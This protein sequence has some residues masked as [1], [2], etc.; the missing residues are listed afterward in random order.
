MSVENK[1]FFEIFKIHQSDE[2][3]AKQWINQRKRAWKKVPEFK[4]DPEILKHSAIICDGN[5]RAAEHKHLPS[6]YGHQAGVEIIKEIS[7]ASRKWGIKTTTFWVMSPENLGRD[8]MEVMFIMDLAYKNF[9]DPVLLEELKENQVRFTHLGR[10]NRLSDELQGAIQNLEEQTK[11]FT[12]YRLN[13]GL[14]YGGLDEMGRIFGK[15]FKDVQEGKLYYDL[16]EKNPKIIL[17]YADTVGQSPIDLVIRTGEKK[18]FPHTS[19]FSPLASDYAS[20]KFL[21][22]LFPNLKPGIILDTIKKFHKSER[23]FGR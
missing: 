10:K 20:W 7:R 8:P 17:N 16:P 23:R 11:D 9:T 19:G 12:S 18:E 5:R 22:I 1:K 4:V 14:D 13:L 2:E 21:P 15:M 3:K 6:F